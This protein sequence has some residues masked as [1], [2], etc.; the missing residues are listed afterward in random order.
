MNQ[1][2]KLIKS[3]YLRLT[4]SKLEY[5]RLLSLEDN[6][7]KHTREQ[8]KKQRE[9]RLKNKNC[10]KRQSAKGLSEEL[11]SDWKYRARQ[12]RANRKGENQ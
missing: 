11:R 6:V 10:L 4:L 5:K 8:R 12:K 9:L 2:L 3:F 1:L 7:A